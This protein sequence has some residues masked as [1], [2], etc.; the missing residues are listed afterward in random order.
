M[1]GRVR[2]PDRR[3]EKPGLPVLLDAAIEV[4]VDRAFVSRG[5]Q[6]LAAALDTWD[7]PIDGRVCLDVGA[8][9][10]GFSDCLLQRG[11]CRVY[12]VDVGYGQLADALRQDPR[13]VGMERTDVRSLRFPI[14]DPM[15]DVGT[16]DVSFIS[17]REVLP[18]LAKL[19]PAGANVVALIKPQFEAAKGAVGHDGVVRSPQVRAAV[20]Q[21]IINWALRAGWRVGGV[22]RSPLTGPKGNEEFLLWLRTPLLAEESEA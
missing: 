11:A 6:K 9:T 16:V 17:L 4:S 12:A 1:A 22:L 19:V 10:G 8:S 13:V 18:A 20:I 5:G 14:L 2:G 3:Y 15:P 7:I 21:E